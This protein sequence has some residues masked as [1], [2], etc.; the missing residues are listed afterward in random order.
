MLTSPDSIP[1]R[2]TRSV[3]ITSGKHG[4]HYFT[5]YCYP[6]IIGNPAWKIICHKKWAKNHEHYFCTPYRS[7]ETGKRMFIEQ[8]NFREIGL[9]AQGF[10][11]SEFK[12]EFYFFKMILENP[13]NILLKEQGYSILLLV[14]SYGL[15]VYLKSKLLTQKN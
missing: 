5:E 4:S 1:G 14:L 10:E 9:E 8:W 6:I 2:R 12:L 11:I 7:P 3:T 15:L 13:R